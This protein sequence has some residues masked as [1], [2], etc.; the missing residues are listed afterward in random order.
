[1]RF[2]RP[3]RRGHAVAMA[4]ALPIGIAD[5]VPAF[6]DPLLVAAAIGAGT[7][8]L[9]GL[10]FRSG[11]SYIHI[12]ERDLE[13]GK[14]RVPRSPA[15]RLHFQVIMHHDARQCLSHAL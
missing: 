1:V 12:M 14:A 3:A 9:D 4:A 15:F 5:A 2:I 6:T 10:D 7:R 8:S 11:R 13:T